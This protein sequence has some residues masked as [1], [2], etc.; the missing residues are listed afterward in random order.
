MRMNRW[1]TG[2]LLAVFLTVMATEAYAVYYTGS[3]P[4]YADVTLD[5]SCLFV[6][7]EAT[8]RFHFGGI[9]PAGYEYEIRYYSN[10]HENEFG[11][12]KEGTTTDDFILFTPPDATRQY[13]VV[14][15][16][17]EED[18]SYVMIESNWFTAVERGEES[19]YTAAQRV[20]GDII[21][22]DMTDLEKVIAI[23]DWICANNVFGTSDRDQ[24]PEG[25]FFDHGGVCN[26]IS[27]AFQI[28]AVECGIPCILPGQ[29]AT[30]EEPAS[31]KWALV[32]LDGIWYHV[33]CTWDDPEEDDYISYQYFLFTDE[34]AKAYNHFHNQIGEEFISELMTPPANG[35]GK[36]IIL[37]SID[38]LPA[39]VTYLPD[40]ENATDEYCILLSFAEGHVN[41]DYSSV[42]LSGARNKYLP[43]G[44]QVTVKRCSPE[45]NGQLYY[46]K[47]TNTPAY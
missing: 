10:I 46:L 9:T 41:L 23:H 14:V 5:T 36:R 25:V 13:S 12:I 39:L 3:A 11:I 30:E 32:Q 34:E 1:K 20:I 27:E 38:Q 8:F 19:V 45:L 18:E 6:G 16:A 28:L 47:V 37:S 42:I 31:H 7:E 35:A 15:V 2:F 21:N 24:K 26:G 17:Y 44:Y 33:D 40:T 4:Q 29:A 43:Q 22:P